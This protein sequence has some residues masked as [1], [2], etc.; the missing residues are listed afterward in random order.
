LLANELLGKDAPVLQVVDMAEVM[1][2][3]KVQ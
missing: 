3:L 2:E 1:A